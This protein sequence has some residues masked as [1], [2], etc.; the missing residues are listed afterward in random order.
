M[1]DDDWDLCLGNKLMGQVHVVTLGT[2]TVGDG[3][4]LTLTSGVL[5]QEPMVGGTAIS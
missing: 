2:D 4:S 1:T 5:A 3:G